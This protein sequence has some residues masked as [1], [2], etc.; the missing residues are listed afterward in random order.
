MQETE[1]ARIE[2]PPRAG[3]SARKQH[4]GLAFIGGYGKK[5]G[6]SGLPFLEGQL[7]TRDGV[8]DSTA[9]AA[10]QMR[11]CLETSNRPLIDKATQVADGR[12]NALQKSEEKAHDCSRGR[13]HVKLIACETTSVSHRVLGDRAPEIRTPCVG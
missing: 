9:P 8:V 11:Q 1:A 3:V 5:I 13:S 6:S 4:H 10:D 7:P 12:S 2:L